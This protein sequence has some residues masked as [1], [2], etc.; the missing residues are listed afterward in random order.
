MLRFVR[1]SRHGGNQP[2]RKKVGWEFDDRNYALNQ[3][4]YGYIASEWHDNHHKYPFSA[5]NG[6]LPGQIDLAFQIIKLL[7][8][9]GIVESY[10]NAKPLF[11]KECLGLSG[12]QALMVGK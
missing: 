2:R 8:R 4:F 12:N 3:W 1:A 9:L 6:F 11:E 7:H 10:V 5:S